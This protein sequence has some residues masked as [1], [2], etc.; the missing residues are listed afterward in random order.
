MPYG[1]KVGWTCC[2]RE[3]THIALARPREGTLLVADRGVLLHEMLHQFLH[4]QGE[5]VRHAGEPWRREIMRLTLAI[6]GQDIWAGASTVRKVKGKDGT[7]RSVRGNRPHPETEAPSL[8]QR[9]IARWP[10]S[11]GLD[12]GTL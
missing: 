10:H 1:T 11:I 6:T 9:A 3:V 8:S 4:E 7:R 12:L 2:L 5:D